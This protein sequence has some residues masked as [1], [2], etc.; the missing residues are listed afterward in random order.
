MEA[1]GRIVHVRDRRHTSKEK[2]VWTHFSLDSFPEA[3]SKQY[4][5][6]LAAYRRINAARLSRKFPLL[7]TMLADGRLHLCGIAVL[8]KHLT[9]AN[10]E[11]VLA[12]ATHKTKRE[13][14]ELVAELALKPDVPPSIRK[15][16]ERRPKPETRNAS[17]A[18]RASSSTESNCSEKEEPP[19][20][21]SA[22][23]VPLVPEKRPKV[24]P[25]SASRFKV[26]FTASGELR[27]KLKRLEALIPGSDLASIID[28]AV[29]EKLER[30]DAKRFGKTNR[31][32]KNV[33]DADTS[34]GK[35]GIPAPVRR[36]R[37]GTGSRNNARTSLAP[38]ITFTW[39][40]WTSEKRKWTRTA[41]RPT[42]WVNR[43]LHSSCVQ[44]H[45]G[46]QT[47]TI[48]GPTNP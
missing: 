47:S 42:V 1:R 33:E 40:R 12:R 48:H 23:N 7:L 30:F 34:P 14:E 22:P 10:H 19:E 26:E 25:L 46:R 45:L 13:L 32:R 18:V 27:D 2:H 39:L 16:P 9:V 35:R 24:E 5:V 41:V 43:G 17:S 15:R 37:M 44:A 28:A 21:R 8:S 20:L 36:G 4:W 29:S 31:P 6:Q 3:S 11:Q 38:P